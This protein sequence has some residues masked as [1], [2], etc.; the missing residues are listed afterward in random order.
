SPI[1]EDIVDTIKKSP[2]LTKATRK[3]MRELKVM[4]YK[5]KQ[6]YQSE[7]TH[8]MEGK[9]Y[10]LY[11]QFISENIASFMHARLSLNPDYRAIQERAILNSRKRVGLLAQI[12]GKNAL[13]FGS[14][15]Y[16][17]ASI[18]ISELTIEWQEIKA[19]LAKYRQVLDDEIFH[20]NRTVKQLLKDRLRFSIYQ[21]ANDLEPNKE[22]DIHTLEILNWINRP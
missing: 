8:S 13:R 21:L 17:R 9:I 18:E 20:L 5:M 4:F 12:E 16:K 1:V 3:Q 15:E 7:T 11:D 22:P 6:L 19:G 14:P 10:S 2:L